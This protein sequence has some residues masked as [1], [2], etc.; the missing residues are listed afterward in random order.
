MGQGSHTR[1]AQVI[2]ENLEIP[3]ENVFIMRTTTDQLANMSDDGG[4]WGSLTSM[5]LAVKD[6]VKLFYNINIQVQQ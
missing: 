5:R 6:R 2:A 4:S 1:V 3:F